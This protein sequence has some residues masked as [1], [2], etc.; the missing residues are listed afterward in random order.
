[1]PGETNLGRFSTIKIFRHYII[2]YELTIGKVVAWQQGTAKTVKSPSGLVTNLI[3]TSA[4][5][6]VRH[7]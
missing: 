7:V 5:L 3:Y 4:R 1:M 2:G 6:F